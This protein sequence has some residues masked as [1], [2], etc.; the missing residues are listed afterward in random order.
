MT[1]IAGVLVDFGVFQ[2][3]KA[4]LAIILASLIK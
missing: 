4:G 2:P 1:V 3:S